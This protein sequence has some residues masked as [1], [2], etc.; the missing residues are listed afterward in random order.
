MGPILD[1]M[2]VVLENIPASAALA[3][4]T[5]SALYRTAQVISAIPN[6]AYH[7]KVS[8]SFTMSSMLPG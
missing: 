5:M 4:T 1:S 7:K 3:R 6:I 2:A 8:A